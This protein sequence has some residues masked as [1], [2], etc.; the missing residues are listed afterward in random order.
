MKNVEII[1]KLV[2]MNDLSKTNLKKSIT[3]TKIGKAA[4]LKAKTL[5]SF[6]IHNIR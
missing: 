6:R 2:L 1:K 4:L 5:T 3:S